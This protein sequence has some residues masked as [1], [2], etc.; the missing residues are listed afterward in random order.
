ML[1]RHLAELG[2]GFDCASIS[3]MQSVLKLKVDPCRIVFANPCKASS[4]LSYAREMGITRTTFDNMDELNKIKSYYPDAELS[5]R[6]FAED[7]TALTSLGDKFGAGMESTDPLL[8]RAREL[9]LNVIGISFHVG[10]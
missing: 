6:I 3:E 8:R 10:R 4:A 2:T 9:N 7:P 1:L 5:L